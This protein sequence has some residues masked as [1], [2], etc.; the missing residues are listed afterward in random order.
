MFQELNILPTFIIV[1]KLV[2]NDMEVQ[3]FI[4]ACFQRILKKNAITNEKAN[5]HRR[6]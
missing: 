4:N 6:N 2:G 3:E 1:K 5:R